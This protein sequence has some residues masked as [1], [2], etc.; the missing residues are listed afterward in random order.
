[1]VEISEVSLARPLPVEIQDGF[2]DQPHAGAV[3]DTEVVD[4]FG[5]AVGSEAEAVAVE[6]SSGGKAICR[7]PLRARRPDLADVF[8]E[9]PKAASAGFRTTID[10]IGTPP[11]FELDVSVVLAD[12]RR[13][14]LATVRGRHRWRRQ[15]SPAFAELLSVVIAWRGG[16]DALAGAIEGVLAQG[17]PR[18]E[19]VVVDDTSVDEAPGIASR[20]PGVRCV[21]GEDD[22]GMAGAWNL[23]IRSTNGDFL[24]FLDTDDRLPPQALEVGLC[25]LERRPEC[26]AA[27]G[28]PGSATPAVY[29]RSL[30]EHLRTFDPRL[31]DATGL[32]FDLAVVRKFPVV[33]L[34]APAAGADELAR[35]LRETLA[36]QV[37]RSLRERRF[38]DALRELA[39]LARHRF[40]APPRPAAGSDRSRPG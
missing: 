26:A 29:R 31:G 12:R 28:P 1:L 40:G 35:L 17:C 21:R 10:L 25:A 22:P 32:G 39:L 19:V 3:L 38:G 23:G 20:Y 6:F 11:E 36:T 34:P 14:E 37:W 15:G 9:R 13:A 7:V 27:I 4:V 16:A 2:L 24:V 18:L 30:F 33:G 8:P 5:W